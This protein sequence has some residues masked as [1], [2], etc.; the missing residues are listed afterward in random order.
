MS[1]K[2]FTAAF[3]KVLAAV[4]A[5][6]ALCAAIGCSSAPATLEAY[7]D[8]HPADLQKE[9]Q[10][11]ESSLPSDTFSGSNVEV[12]DNHIIMTGELNFD[13]STLDDQTQQKMLSAVSEYLTSSENTEM[14]SDAVKNTENAT[15]ISGITLTIAYTDNAGRDLVSQTYDSQGI[16]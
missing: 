6:F 1:P 11:F 7:Y 12:K 16:V 9:I 8:A 15:G 14:L 4:A 5:C 10:D 13:F 2:P 3:F